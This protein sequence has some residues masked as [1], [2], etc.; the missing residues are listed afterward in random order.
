MN[1]WGAAGHSLFEGA[2]KRKVLLV[3]GV[4]AAA[5]TV[6]VLLDSQVQFVAGGALVNLG[7]RLQD[8]LQDFDFKHHDDIRPDEVWAEFQSQNAMAS[9]V[10]EQFPRSTYHPLVAMLVCMDARIDTNELAGDTRRNYYVVRTAGSV[11][12]AREEEMLELAVANGV[13]VIVLTRHT[14]CAAER[15]AADPELRARY[16]AL[17]QGIDERDAR[18]AEF[19]ARPSIAKQL[20]AGKLLV[21]QLVIDTSTE[22]VQE[23]THAPPLAAHEAGAHP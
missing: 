23:G 13:K 5:T 2:M 18:I 22:H 16:P 8:P 6:Y 17:V 12:S 7:Y 21:K 14:D 4:L 15:A 10:R 9:R 1:L 3:C 19:L 11:M 20:A